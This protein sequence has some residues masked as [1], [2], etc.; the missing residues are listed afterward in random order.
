MSCN[1]SVNIF[2]F[3]LASG[4]TTDIRTSDQN[5]QILM[6]FAYAFSVTLM[7]T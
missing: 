6:T 1:K 3:G 2:L 4:M 5:Q 7:V